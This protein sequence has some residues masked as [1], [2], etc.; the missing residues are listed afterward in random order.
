M[1][2]IGVV[3]DYHFNSLH[4]K[5]EPIIHF[6]SSGPRYYLSVR[7]NEGQM[8]NALTHIEESWLEFNSKRPF[9]YRLLKDIQEEMYQGEEKINAIFMV[10]TSLTVFIALL[11]LFGLAS[12]STEQRTHEIGIRKVNGATVGDILMLLYREFFWLIL[13]GFVLAIPIAWWRLNIWLESS[14]IYY[15]DIKWYTILLAGALAMI[16]GL[17]TISFHVTRAASRN[18]VDAIKYE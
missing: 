3:K 12:F 14:F 1:R 16:V 10:I 4:N 6:I 13:V 11:G 7:Y 17:A 9:D 2:V 15:V 5:I 8:T 18:P